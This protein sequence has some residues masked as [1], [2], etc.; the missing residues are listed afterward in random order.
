VSAVRTYRAR[1]STYCIRLQ[2]LAQLRANGVDFAQ[3]RLILFFCILFL[4][5]RLRELALRRFD[6]RCVLRPQLF[7]RLT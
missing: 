1:T 3:E 6:I 7:E 4:G 5:L 2:S